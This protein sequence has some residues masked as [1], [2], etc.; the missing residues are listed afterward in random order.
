MIKA[1]FSPEQVA[2]LNRWQITGWVHPFTCANRNDGS[3]YDGG[4]LVATTRGWICPYC[5]HTQSWAHKHMLTPPD[6]PFDVM[7]VLRHKASEA[8]DELDA[9]IAVARQ[10]S[11]RD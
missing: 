9:G 6:N 4:W 3:H 10:R 5:T 7:D 11:E 8:L 1:P 2:A